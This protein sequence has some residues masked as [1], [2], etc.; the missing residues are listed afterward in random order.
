LR[1]ARLSSFPPFQGIAPVYYS[2][3]SPAT[4]SDPLGWL[5]SSRLSFLV[6]C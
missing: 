3:F 1:I 6:L 2:G 4:K 5:W